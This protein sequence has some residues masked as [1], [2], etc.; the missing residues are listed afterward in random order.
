MRPFLLLTLPA[1]L[2]AQSQYSI[3][4]FAGF[5][6]LPPPDDQATAGQI[7]LVRPS[8]I[9][10]DGKG[11]LFLIDLY[12]QRVMRIAADGTIT[13]AAGNGEEGF[14]G[15]GGPAVNASLRSPQALAV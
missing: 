3:D 1:L 4:T 11:N 10:S 9:A 15:D 13:V 5:G 7:R 14:D 2:L 8:G 12:Y 6:K